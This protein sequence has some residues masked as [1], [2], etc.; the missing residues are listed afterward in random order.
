M[1]NASGRADIP[2]A[3]KRRRRKRDSFRGQQIAMNINR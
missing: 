2:V 3:H 1:G